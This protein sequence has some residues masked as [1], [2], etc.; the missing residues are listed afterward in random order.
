[1]ALTKQVSLDSFF[2]LLLNFVKRIKKEEPNHLDLSYRL[3]RNYCNSHSWESITLFHAYGLT[4]FIGAVYFRLVIKM[5]RS[6]LHECV[7][8]PYSHAMSFAAAD[9]S[10][11]KVSSASNISSKK[12]KALQEVISPEGILIFRSHSFW[13]L[14]GKWC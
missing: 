10:G 11:R 3:H 2:G 5:Y 12:E 13:L 1:M 8:C 9:M 14:T 6:H 7:S 4:M